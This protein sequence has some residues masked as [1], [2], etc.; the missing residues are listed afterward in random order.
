MQFSVSRSIIPF[1]LPC[2]SGLIHDINITN[3]LLHPQGIEW[4]ST[5]ACYNGCLV[6]FNCPHNDLQYK[7]LL[8]DSK[9][10]KKKQRRKYQPSRFFFG[11]LLFQNF[12]S[13]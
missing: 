9:K 3:S 11:F 6:H 7:V 4:D 12:A 13:L 1:H 8:L 10:K 2:Y 5:V